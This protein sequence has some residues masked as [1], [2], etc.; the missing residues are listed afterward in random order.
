[1][2]H[3]II[4]LSSLWIQTSKSSIWLKSGGVVFPSKKDVWG[5]IKDSLVSVLGAKV[6]INSLSRMAK[7][8]PAGVL[9]NCPETRGELIFILEIGVVTAAEGV[10]AKDGEES[11]N[12]GDKIV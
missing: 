3:I 12:F 7:R 5:L 1:M 9:A 6:V 4:G 11:N 10:K 2:H 8:F